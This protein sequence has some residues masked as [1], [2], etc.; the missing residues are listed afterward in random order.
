[1][2]EKKLI[3]TSE[4]QETAVLIG[5]TT[6]GQSDAQTQEY[7]DELAFLAETSGA[8]TLRYFTQKLP[9]PD[10]RTFVGSGK[11]E[12]IKIY[13]EEH[14]VDIIIFDDELSPSQLRNI[15]RIL[16]EKFSI[17]II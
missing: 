17:E 13:V 8:K 15:E 11:I 5:L 14:D 12:E 10:T 3:S 4:E 1:M 16:E 2:L 9:K 7:L 6:P